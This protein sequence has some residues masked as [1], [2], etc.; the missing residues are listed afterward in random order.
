MAAGKDYFNVGEYE[1][2]QDNRLLAWAEDDVGRR[3]YTIR[4]RNLDTG[5]ACPDVITGVSPN[6]VWADDNRTVFYVEN[7]P[8]TL[9]TVR[10]KK[11]VLGTPVVDD[12][13]AYEAHD[14]SF[15]TGAVRT[16]AAR[17][18][19]IRLAS[20]ISSA[21]RTAPAPHPRDHPLPATPPPP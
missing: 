10:V 1:V 4:F 9:L 13:L 8:Q 16:R 19:C 12:A 3:Q 14:D 7:D 18:T 21:P 17:Y 15:Y 5:E 11:H 20:T 6:L 2:S